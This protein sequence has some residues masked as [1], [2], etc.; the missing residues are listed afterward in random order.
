MSTHTPDHTQRAQA[1]QA[2]PPYIRTCPPGTCKVKGFE[3][4]ICIV[5]PLAFHEKALAEAETRGATVERE[6][7]A[8]LLEQ[9]IG[10][11][12]TLDDELREIAKA[13]RRRQ[14]GTP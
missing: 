1:V 14:Q 11:S 10:L 13:I 4:C 2:E 3:Q 7:C 5:V 12:Y 6:A 8:N 9:R